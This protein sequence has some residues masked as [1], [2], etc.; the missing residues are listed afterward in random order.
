MPFEGASSLKLAACPQPAD[1]GYL[2][3]FFSCHSVFL[4]LKS[5]SAGYVGGR[6]LPGTDLMAGVSFSD[7]SSAVVSLLT[8][9]SVPL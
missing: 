2:F 9:H 4:S 7:M 6:R 8:S 1:V 3:C 5:R